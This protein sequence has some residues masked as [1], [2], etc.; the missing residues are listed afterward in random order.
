MEGAAITV[1]KRRLG[2]VKGKPRERET[3]TPLRGLA[4]NEKS[5][6]LPV[7]ETII[8]P[9]RLG[10]ENNHRQTRS[11]PRELKILS[12]GGLSV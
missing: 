10:D 1:L 9:L 5:E 12:E 8:R 2:E 4:S 7:I 3:E 6:Q 11:Y